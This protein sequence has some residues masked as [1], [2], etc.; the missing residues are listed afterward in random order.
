[1]AREDRVVESASTRL[2]EKAGPFFHARAERL[3][4]R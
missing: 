1:M 2:S 4:Y 3:P